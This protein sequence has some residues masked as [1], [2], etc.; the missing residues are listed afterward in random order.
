M[1]RMQKSNLPSVNV[2]A[3]LC[4][5]ALIPAV[6]VIER[7]TVF[8][9]EQSDAAERVDRQAQPALPQSKS[10]LR[11][12]IDGL[13]EKLGDDDYHVRRAAQEQLAR[14]GFGAFDALSEAEHHKDAEVAARARYL[15]RLLQVDFVDKNDSPR[16]KKILERYRSRSTPDKI[17]KMRA[18]ADLPKGE[19]LA[20]LC[21]LVRFQ[22]SLLLSK[23]AA[24]A[25]LQWQIDNRD[26]VAQTAP[27]ILRMLGSSERISTQWLRESLRFSS[28]PKA[29]LARWTE[30]VHRER[31]LLVRGDGQTD[32]Q[33]L[34][35]LITNELHWIFALGLGDEEKVAA[36]KSLV[37]LRRNDARALN[38]LVPW[39]VEQEAWK[40]LQQKPS[41]FADRFAA[42]TRIR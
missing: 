39:L 4:W 37:S 26:L 10:A 14:L 15:L 29:A 23:H 24:A 22:R 12:R 36:F 2:R 17:K 9:S 8:A 16:V 34:K 41:E 19:G 3:A 1:P 30:F 5:L 21:R 27:S 40:P 6:I 13:V 31:D 35:Q 32:S 20:A 11:Q 7:E 18:L 28:E 38:L 25:I 33:V 42:I